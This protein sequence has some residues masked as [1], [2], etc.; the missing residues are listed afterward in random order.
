MLFLYHSALTDATSEAVVRCCPG[1]PRK[2]ASERLLR[3]RRPAPRLASRQPSLAQYVDNGNVVAVSSEETSEF[4]LVVAEVL[5]SSTTSPSRL[6]S[7]VTRSLTQSVSSL[8]SA[9][10]FGG[11]ATLVAGRCTMPCTSSSASALRTPWRCAASWG[12][13]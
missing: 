11:I 4:F 13:S 7:Q 1:L 10:V 3:D 2:G 12:T 8:I 5:K 6:R 9:H